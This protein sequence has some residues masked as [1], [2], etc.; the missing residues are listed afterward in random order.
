MKTKLRTALGTTADVDLPADEIRLPA[1][2]LKKL[3]SAIPFHHSPAEQEHIEPVA[4]DVPPLHPAK[5]K[6]HDDH[7]AMIEDYDADVVLNGR[8]KEAP[9]PLGARL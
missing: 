9:A 7:D 8:P 2:E 6:W 5:R 1:S 3:E 4:V